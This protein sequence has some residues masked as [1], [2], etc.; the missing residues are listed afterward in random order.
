MTSKKSNIIFCFLVLF[1][2]A[3]A[4]AQSTDQQNLEAKREAL[5]KEIEDINRLL[6]A[7]KKERGNVLDQMEALDKK[8]KVRQ[9]L[10]DVTN[11]QSKALNIEINENIES[12]SI[13]KKELQ[14]RKDEYASLIQK[15]YQ[16]KTQQSR[17]MFLLSSENFV[18]AMKRLQYIKQYTDY[19]KSQGLAILSK[20]DELSERNLAL[21]EQRKKADRLIAA[22]KKAKGEI[23]K[24]IKVQKELL[25]SIR[26]NESQ[27][28]AEVQKK[29]K[30][31]KKID[32]QIEA[33]IRA[34]IVSSNAKNEKEGKKSVISNKFVLTPE[35]S[36]VADNFAANKGK[37]IWP[38]DKGIKS[39]GFGIYEDAV[40]PEIKHESNGVIITTEEGTRARA[41]FQGEVIAIMS[42]PGGNNGVTLKHGNYISTYYNLSVLF[43]KKGDVVA[44]KTEL[45]KVATN[46]LNGQTRLK[47]YLYQDTEKLNPE[48]W[49]YQL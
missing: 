30:E 22:N 12:I 43:V 46:R 5:Q 26:K 28:A 19:R 4:H 32:Q 45:G 21:T 9:E 10:I 8:I 6:F 40:Y 44:A 25:A 15:S 1:I 16:S 35:A 7:E 38:V 47:F 37:L 14:E 23:M 36:L 3:G 34:A 11:K 13:L 31:T 18:Q 42:V 29:K 49:V 24:E 41:I 33:L 39:Q 48:D 20:T 27:Y 17:L 2:M